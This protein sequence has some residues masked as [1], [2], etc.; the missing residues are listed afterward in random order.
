ML[1][2]LLAIDW[3]RDPVHRGISIIP[4]DNRI[5]TSLAIV[6]GFREGRR[7]GGSE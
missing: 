7:L 4:L 5:R 6:L 3:C 2:V 1:E